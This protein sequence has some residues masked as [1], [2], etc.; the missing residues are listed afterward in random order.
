[1]FSSGITSC[2]ACLSESF[3]C[4]SLKLLV[5]ESLGKSISVFYKLPHFYHIVGLTSPCNQG[6]SGSLTLNPQCISIPP[7]SITLVFLKCPLLTQMFSLF[8]SSA[9]GCLTMKEPSVRPVILASLSFSY[10]V[11]TSVQRFSCACLY[12]MFHIIISLNGTLHL[13]ISLIL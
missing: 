11:S 8:F 7:S 3:Q 4:I 2:N 5:A 10:H 13:M 1:M 9:H 6:L 12:V